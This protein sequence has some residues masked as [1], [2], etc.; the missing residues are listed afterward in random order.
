MAKPRDLGPFMD[1]TKLCLTA[2]MVPGL[3]Y[4]VDKLVQS[5]RLESV[6]VRHASSAAGV[7]ANAGSIAKRASEPFQAEKANCYST[8]KGVSL[9]QLRQTRVERP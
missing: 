9:A 1:G 4:S 2:S 6:L 7:R 5:G 3:L 8:P